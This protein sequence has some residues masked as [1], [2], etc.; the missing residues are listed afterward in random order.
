[1]TV[2]KAVGVR[3]VADRALPGAREVLRGVDL[4]MCGGE[5]VGLVGCSGAGKTTLALI[6]AGL[7]EPDSG[8]VMRP[9]EACG[10]GLVFQ[11]PE[12]AFFG[13][14]VLEDVAFG[15]RNA[16]VAEPRA[17]DLAR[18]ALVAVGLDPDRYGARAPHTL[19]GGEARR[20]AIAGVLVCDPPVV[21]FDEPTVGLDAEG[22]R[23]LR[24]VIARLTADDRAVGIISHDLS[25]L[26]DECSRILVLDGGC[27]AW[28][29]APADLPAGLPPQWREDPAAWGGE[30]A[31]LVA[32]LVGRGVLK[33]AVP[34]N[35]E[36]VA[37]AWLAQR[38]N[39]V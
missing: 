19:S 27:I 25:F 36:L 22:V 9:G 33:D 4:E 2:L 17:V 28:E 7:L 13:E 35:P 31:E 30:L 15:A 37:A 12:R 26:A 38:R 23:S 11:D 6:L 39:E 34:P 29:G 8:E 14:T 3:W 20:A 21:L 18:T 10:V 16:G 32:G 5:S 24:E 1:M